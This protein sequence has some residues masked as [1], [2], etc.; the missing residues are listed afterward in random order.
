MIYENVLVITFSPKTMENSILGSCFQGRG[1]PS[2]PS[3]A[4]VCV[5]GN[6]RFGYTLYTLIPPTVQCCAQS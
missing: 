2:P 6:A 4:G 1:P 5:H 3:A